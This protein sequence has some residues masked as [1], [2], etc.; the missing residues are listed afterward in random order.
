MADGLGI[1][2]LLK[3]GARGQRQ[4][5]GRMHVTRCTVVPPNTVMCVQCDVD[6]SYEGN[7]CL[8]SP[9]CGRK[10]LAMLYA[11]VNVKGGEIVTHVANLSDHFVTLCKGYALGSIEE[12][13][14]VIE[15]SSQE[16]TVP[17]VR[18]SAT[19]GSDPPA[20]SGSTSGTGS[21]HS[22]SEILENLPYKTMDEV[23]SEMPVFMSEMFANLCSELTELSVIFGN[24]PI[25]F[26]NTFVKDDTD[27]GCFIGV[28]HHIDMGDAK[29][30]KQ[31]M[32]CIPM[33]FM[34]EEEK[35]LKKMLDYKVIRPSVSE[36]A[37]PSVLI[38]K[39][40]G[41]IHWCIDFRAINAVTRK[42][43]YPLPLIEQCLDSLAGVVFRWF[44]FTL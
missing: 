7:M 18:R 11:T 4:N 31:P 26:R 21:C 34:G 3:R 2:A 23:N 6:E 15:E 9:G 12:I 25:E 5:V 27:L 17:K 33:A 43:A 35:D 20:A 8:I 38:R 29:P 28:E 32:H 40:D 24:L 14:E 39:R 10:A 36:W 37:S 42:D 13:D 1:P 44:K 30:I 41:D 22:T 16:D 19:D